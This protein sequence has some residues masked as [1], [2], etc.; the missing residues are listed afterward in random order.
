MAGRLHGEIQKGFI[1]AEVTP[2][3]VLLDHTNYSA[4]KDAGCVRA[5]G[6]EY[7]LQ[8]NDVVLIKWK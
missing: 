4:A 7:E 3:S 8:S 1:R 5:E 6:R 2:A